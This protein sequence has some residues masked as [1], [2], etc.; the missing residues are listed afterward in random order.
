MARCRLPRLPDQRAAVRRPVR[1]ERDLHVHVRLR[2]DQRPP[3]VH[4]QGLVH[5][6]VVL[7]SQPDARADQETASAHRALTAAVQPEPEPVAA[8]R[9]VAAQTALHD[10][11]DLHP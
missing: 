6:P 9:A 10:L 11:S 8:S 4:V 2:E 1:P 5:L 7:R 3:Y